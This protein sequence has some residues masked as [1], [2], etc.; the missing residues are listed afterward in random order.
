[1]TKRNLTEQEKK[2]CNK[3]IKIL[4]GELAYNEALIKRDELAV[5]L[6]PIFYEHQLNEMK[7]RIEQ[8]REN[9][10]NIKE[11]IKITSEQVR[12][13]VEIKEDKK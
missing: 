12:N 9:L 7:G 3:N 2:L 11:G 1:M 8:T 4:E 10:N 5:E 6:A 13:G